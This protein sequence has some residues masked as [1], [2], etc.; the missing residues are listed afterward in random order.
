MLLHINKFGDSINCLKANSEFSSIISSMSNFSFNQI[1]SFGSTIDSFEGLGFWIGS[2]VPCLGNIFGAIIGGIIGAIFY[3]I[4]QLLGGET[5]E[6]KAK[7]KIDNELNTNVKSEITKNI[8]SN[9]T[10]ILNDCRQ[11]VIHPLHIQLDNNIKDVELMQKILESKMAMMKE[12]M[13][14]INEKQNNYEFNK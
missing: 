4:S 12:L 13:F 11:K 9:N 6:A 3:G 1:L 5:K 14:N 8:N 10:Q 2:I 7:R